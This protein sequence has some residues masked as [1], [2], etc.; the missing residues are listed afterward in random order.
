MAT[1]SGSVIFDRN[2]NAAVSSEDSG[3]AS[4][5][6]VLQN[7][8]TSARLTVQTDNAGNYSFVN[9][10]DGSYR[11]VEAY[12]ISGGIPSP[13]DF[14]AASP[15]DVPQG[16]NPP[17][18]AIANP[19]A[20]A[21]HLDAVTPNTLMVEVVAADLT[22]QN[23]LNGPVTYTPIQ[24]ILDPCAII[25]GDNRITD[26]DS[27][28]FG[29]FVQG[30]EANTGASTEPYP[31]VTPDFAY[32]LPNPAVYAP[33]GGEYT[34]QNIMNN[35]ASNEIGAWWRIADH[36]QGNETGRMMVVNGFNP[37]AVFFAV[38]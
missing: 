24:T 25:S 28:T 12:G 22:N 23:F 21:T 35:A 38:S 2:R 11:I 37:G 32:V 5:P 7:I 34:V 30:T 27:G 19:P 13:G 4:I 10:P 8:N 26:A 14:S 31:G 3:I 20:V 6:V 33:M 18:S 16:R 29:S 1:I 15:G 36:T 17:I 9:V